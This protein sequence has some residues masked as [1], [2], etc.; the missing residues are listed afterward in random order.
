MYVRMYA[1]E[2]KFINKLIYFLL[3]F[4]IQKTNKFRKQQLQQKSTETSKSEWNSHEMKA[5][6][7]K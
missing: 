6:N 3:A 4:Q 7:H 5:K 1:I 2:K